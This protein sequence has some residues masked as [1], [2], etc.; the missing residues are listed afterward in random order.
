MQVCAIFKCVIADLLQVVKQGHALRSAAAEGSGLH[1]AQGIREDDRF[2]GRIG[3]GPRRNFHDGCAAQRIGDD[4]RF[5]PALPARYGCSVVFDRVGEFRG[6]V[7][8]CPLRVKPRTGFGAAAQTEGLTAAVRGGVPARQRVPGAGKQRTVDGGVQPQMAGG[9]RHSD[10]AAAAVVI[11]IQH[12]IALF[13]GHCHGNRV[14]DIGQ[15]QDVRRAGTGKQCTGV[16]STRQRIAVGRG[17]GE[18]HRL[19]RGNGYGLGLRCKC[20]RGF[21]NDAALRRG[22]GSGRRTGRQQHSDQQQRKQA[23]QRKVTSFRN[24]IL[25]Y[26]K[27][28]GEQVP[29]VG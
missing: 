5:S 20:R 12:S 27:D 9:D 13:C 16:V 22:L 10:P 3:K 11:I 1:A 25:L 23:A 8:S 29:G 18:G 17:Q 26:R 4:K 28:P 24:Y 15:R 7:L 2:T 14:A 19:P 6:V 21:Q